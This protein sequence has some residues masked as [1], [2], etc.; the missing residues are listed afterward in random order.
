[1][2][3]KGF[4]LVELLVVIAII[5]ILATIV[6]VVTSGARDATRDARIITQLSQIR[7]SAEVFYT[8]NSFTYGDSTDALVDDICNND[9][10]ITSLF[11]DI[12]AQAGTAPLCAADD[13]DDDNFCVS[14]VM[15]TTGR[16]AMCVSDVG[17]MSEGEVCEDDPLEAAFATCVAE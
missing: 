9:A 5:G 13:E 17:E 12:E 1:M 11:D 16:P 10:D 4:T 15:A 7:S 6:I 14:S 3:K 2:N 8:V